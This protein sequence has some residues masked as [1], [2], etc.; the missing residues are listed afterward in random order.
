MFNMVKNGIKGKKLNK[1]KSQTVWTKAIVVSNKY[2]EPMWL[3]SN[4]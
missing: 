3:L 1:K 4:W 2:I